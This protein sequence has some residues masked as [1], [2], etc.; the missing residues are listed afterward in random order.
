MTP[1]WHNGEP[2]KS[3]LK[4]IAEYFHSQDPIYGLPRP[5]LYRYRWTVQKL[6]HLSYRQN[7]SAARIRQGKPRPWTRLIAS[8]QELLYGAENLTNPTMSR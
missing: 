8:N 1:E 3:H 4:K 6:Y 7:C 2:A 5:P